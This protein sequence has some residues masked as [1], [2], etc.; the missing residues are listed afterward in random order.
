MSISTSALNQHRS[1]QLVLFLAVSL[2]V[3]FYSSEAISRGSW[4][5]TITDVVKLVGTSASAAVDIKTLVQELKPTLSTAES[6]GNSDLASFNLAVRNS[7]IQPMYM[8]PFTPSQ[9]DT[10]NGGYQWLNQLQEVATGAGNSWVPQQSQGFAGIDLSGVWNN[11]I[12]NT[13][14]YYIRQF[15]PYIN[16]ILL[17][18]GTPVGYF[19]GLFNPENG[20]VYL[21]G[22]NYVGGVMIMEG[23]VNP[24]WTT[25]MTVYSYNAYGQLFYTSPVSMQ[26]A[27]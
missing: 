16:L 6:T 27:S 5:K 18:G 19:E 17:M 4:V 13:E 8:Q 22:Q 7:D 12:V 1:S 26:K 11:P 14:A 20:K 3:F 15:G 9:V 23:E 21:Y 25:Q 24:D 2:V 10:Y